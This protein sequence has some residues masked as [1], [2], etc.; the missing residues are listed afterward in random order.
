M[1]I[2]KLFDDM[3]Y[4]KCRDAVATY[5]RILETPALSTAPAS[6]QIA[7]LF[8]AERSGREGRRQQSMIRAAHLHEIACPED[9]NYRAVRGLD[10]DLM[11]QLLLL[12]WVRRALN[13][14]FT[15]PAGCGKSWLACA[16][17]MQAIRSWLTVLYVRAPDLL[18]EFYVARRDGTLPKH[19][20]KLTRPKLL[21]LDDLGLGTL[22]D[23]G[24]SDF[25]ELVHAREKKGSMIII[26]QRPFDQWYHLFGDPSH[27][28]SA[29]DRLAYASHHI[30]LSGPSMRIEDGH[31]RLRASMAGS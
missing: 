5:E 7:M 15:G 11:A 25:A 30:V 9:I 3:K 24:R 23:E 22:T 17:A 16:L 1:L 10:R 2:E 27:A 19:R 29:L 18:E 31:E 28:D 21:I 14:T 12:E 6:D 20:A 26:S 4:C 8:S 13:V